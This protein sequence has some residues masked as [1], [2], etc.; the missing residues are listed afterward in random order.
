VTTTF[1]QEEIEDPDEGEC[2]DIPK[3]K[4]F[5]KFKICWKIIPFLVNSN[6]ENFFHLW[7]FRISNLIIVINYYDYWA[8][9]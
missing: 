9:I 7:Q 2:C 5:L 8:E 4:V 6:L 1:Q 3:N